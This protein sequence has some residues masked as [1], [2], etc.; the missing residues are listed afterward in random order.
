[1]EEK[2]IKIPQDYIETLEVIMDG[3][4]PCATGSIKING[5]EVKGNVSSVELNLVANKKPDVTLVCVGHIRE[6]ARKSW[7]LE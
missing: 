4:Y 3:N 2:R 6:E 5:F 1:M 7:G